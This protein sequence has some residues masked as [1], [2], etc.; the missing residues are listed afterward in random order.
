MLSRAFLAAAVRAS[1]LVSVQQAIADV[2]VNGYTKKDGTY[3]APH[4]RSD[5]DGNPNNN[6]SHKG[7]VNPHTGQ[8]GNK[9]TTDYARQ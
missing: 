1:A 8:P 4:W 2:H 6:W 5:P 3:V 7:N 9:Y